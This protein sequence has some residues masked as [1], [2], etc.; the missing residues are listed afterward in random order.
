MYCVCVYV[1]RIL[2]P[3]KLNVKRII[4]PTGVSVAAA[5]HYIIQYTTGS[6]NGG[7]LMESRYEN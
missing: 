2:D 6:D 7:A 3:N 5:A 1:S 4:P